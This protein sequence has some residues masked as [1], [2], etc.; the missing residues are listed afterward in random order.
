MLR[1]LLLVALFALLVGAAFVF[2][3][4]DASSDTP[5]TGLSSVAPIPSLESEKRLPP[6]DSVL[7]V[8]PPAP[9]SSPSVPA[10][11]ERK[12]STVDGIWIEDGTPAIYIRSAIEGY[13]PAK[14]FA[15]GSQVFENM[16]GKVRNA[17]GQMEDRKVTISVNPAKVAPVSPL[18][19]GR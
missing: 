17:Q 5:R 19:S 3:R 11:P 2:A 1:T 15:D 10:K 13:K 12:G 4:S 8:P 9:E 7:S 16:P 6:A 18:E 14:I